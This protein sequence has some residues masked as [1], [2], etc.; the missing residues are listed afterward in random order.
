MDLLEIA[1]KYANNNA[2][3][4][5]IAKEILHYDILETLYENEIGKFLVFQGG[6]ALRLFYNN[7]RYSEDLDFV[8]DCGFEF[9]LSDMTFFKERF[10]KRI[11]LKY[12]L[13]IEF[14]E[15]KDDDNIVKRYSVKILL[16]MPNRQ[17]TKINLEIAQ[18]PSYDNDLKIINNQYSSEFSVN[19]LVRVESK[20]EI[21]ADKMIALACRKYL[22]FRDFWDIKFLND[23]NT[24]LNMELIKAKIKDYK[25]ENFSQMLENKMNLLRENNLA[26]DFEN[27]MNRFLDPKFFNLTKDNNFL[28]DILKAVLYNSTKV[29]ENK[30]N[31]ES[32]KYYSTKPKRKHK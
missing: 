27:E 1:A 23:S 14:D 19:T 2:L 30:E 24:P 7:N 4:F 32:Q 15:P 6:T 20:E 18:I 11:A 25:I 13:E 22:K 26:N 16:P 12:G 28:N 3:Q 31:L 29:L 8:I 17:K 5:T 9:K 10:Q 21:F